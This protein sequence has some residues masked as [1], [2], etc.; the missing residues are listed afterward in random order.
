M[1][2]SFLLL[3]PQVTAAKRNM[4][5]TLS[6]P[7]WEETLRTLS[8][9]SLTC[10]NLGDYLIIMN[11]DVDV[12]ICGEPYTA[13]Q[14]WFEKKS[15]KFL[16]RVWNETVATGRVENI[17][18]FIDICITHLKRRP[19]IGY[20]TDDLGQK[21]QEFVICPTT[22]PRKMSRAC[23][24]VLESDTSTTVK[25]CPECLLFTQ[26][27]ST[28]YETVQALNTGLK[29][30]SKLS[31][32]ENSL[33]L[34]TK[35]VF[36]G[37]GQD[38]NLPESGDDE[39]IF[40]AN[41][42]KYDKAAEHTCEI[43]GEGF[44][45]ISSWKTHAKTIHDGKRF[46][47]KLCSFKTDHRSLLIRHVSGVHDKKRDHTCP[48]CGKAFTQK[49]S[50]MRHI[51]K[52]HKNLRIEEDIACKI[53]GEKFQSR[54]RWK[55]HL[56]SMHDGKQFQ[57]NMCAFKA[58]CQTFLMR[59]VNGV[60]NKRKDH[61]CEECGMKFAQKASMTR[62]IKV[63]HKKMASRR[64]LH[65]KC[66][67]CGK[68]FFCSWLQK[69]M[70]YEHGVDVRISKKCPWCDKAVTAPSL[71]WHAKK[72]HFYGKFS[73]TWC[74]FRADFATGLVQH[75][76]EEHA[77][78][79][80]SAHCPCCSKTHPLSQIEAHYRD[81][82]S[83]KFKEEK[84]KLKCDKIC[85]TCGKIFNTRKKYY[86]HMK[87][88]SQQQALKGEEQVQ[89]RNLFFY[90]DKCGKR[91]MS[92]NSLKT[93]NELVHESGNYACP[94][95]PKIFNT[96]MQQRFHQNIEHSTDEKFKCRYCNLRLGSLPMRK[97]H[98]L[99]HKE[100]EFECE[101]C[102]KKLKS[103]INLIAH[104]RYHTGEKPFE[105]SECASCFVALNALQQHMKGV[106]KIIGPK[107]GKPGWKNKSEVKQRAM[108]N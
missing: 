48:G 19:C 6:S 22:I 13:I 1:H 50:M 41:P 37:D 28:N 43:C 104:E 71:S 85:E 21:G 94:S 20:P 106:H 84:E 63:I 10:A 66:H 36:N 23:Q 93:H 49:A 34:E 16:G 29:V 83:K 38:L 25:S 55:E 74:K 3:F 65:F 90:C 44:P 60:H 58:N 70:K 33:E 53:C 73:C 35:E 79:E 45:D 11:E 46:H 4:E 82:V 18:Q 2:K 103:R 9:L 27:G 64:P 57:C 5:S 14:L 96:I 97:R 26:D 67:I 76:T 69:H 12:I 68:A 39:S 99:T 98:E 59:H 72:V 61:I 15:C 78:K 42:E 52:N 95:C 80:Q 51:D 91:L 100:P 89:S 88:H 54:S 47:C 30:E 8:T 105:C 81:C 56:E 102:N 87:W 77:K 62:H 107:G 86:V 40:L 92:S 108:P 101:Y 7:I 75:I 24:K 31:N 32:S 17:A